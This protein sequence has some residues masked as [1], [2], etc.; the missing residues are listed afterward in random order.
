MGPTFWTF[1][2]VVVVPVTTYFTTR[3]TL[4]YTDRRE[5]ARLEHE[6]FLKITE[7]RHQRQDK[8]RE[9]CVAAYRTLLTR[10]QRVNYKEPYT[11]LDLDE[12]NS[13]VQLVS[14]SPH[15]RR[16]SAQLVD[17]CKKAREAATDA[18]KEDPHR[19]IPNVAGVKR[20]MK[21]KDDMW[22]GLLEQAIE[23]RRRMSGL[24]VHVPDPQPR[25]DEPS[26]AYTR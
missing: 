2:I 15:V 24:V 8:R 21:E 16:F 23:D 13:E 7:L 10:T 9:E 12:A 19:D 14:D 11:F 6:R 20:A 1:V 26:L 17:R 3:M 22:K 4:R 25:D 18:Y 5:E